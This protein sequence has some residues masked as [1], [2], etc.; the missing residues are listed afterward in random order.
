VEGDEDLSGQDRRRGSS[1]GFS[2]QLNLRTEQRRQSAHRLKVNGVCQA[3]VRRPCRQYGSGDQQIIKAPRSF[4]KEAETRKVIYMLI[5][6]MAVFF[7]CWTP[8][9]TYNTLAA[10]ELL[11]FGNSGT[12]RTKH[13]KTT[14][15]LLSYLNSCLNPIIYGFMSKSFRGSFKRSLSACSCTSGPSTSSR[16]H[17]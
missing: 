11:G 1:I 9:L 5:L 7:L 12:G 15:S 6:I 14:F 17:V 8:I 2:Q 13:L 16:N 10:F 4:N 3:S